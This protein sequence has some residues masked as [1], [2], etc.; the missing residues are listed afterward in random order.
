[1]AAAKSKQAKKT[2][3]LPEQESK[4]PAPETEKDDTQFEQDFLNSQNKQSLSSN[5]MEESQSTQYEERETFPTQDFSGSRKSFNAKAAVYIVL[6]V[7]ALG[8]LVG[9]SIYYFKTRS[10][11]AEVV[12]Q[13]RTAA[14]TPTPTEAQAQ[15][16][17][18]YN[19][20]IL[21]GSGIAGQAGKVKALLEEAGFEDFEV[22]NADTYDYT[23]TE[24][25][26]MADIPNALFAKIEDALSE[27]GYSIKKGAA[28]S[29]EGDFDIVITVGSKGVQGTTTTATPTPKP[30]TSTPSATTA[31][32][33]PKPTATK[34]PTPT[35][36]PTKAL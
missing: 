26:M 9:G 6:A 7:V 18:E 30:K 13:E 24:V 10:Q 35:P 27:A 4:T 19:V 23:D 5:K 1:M 31:T 16:L 12:E 11:Q 8:A 20:Q 14:P 33:T 34:A 15:D 17:S 36:T 3:E 32:P 25:R 29:S 21:N 2:P 22:G 28:L